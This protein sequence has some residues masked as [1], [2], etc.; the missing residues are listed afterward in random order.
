MSLVK[1]DCDKIPSEYRDAYPFTRQGV[2]VFLGEIANMKGHC[3]VAD[4]ITGQIY[5][6]YHSE[7]F[8]EISE[9]KLRIGQNAIEDGRPVELLPRPSAEYRI[10][11]RKVE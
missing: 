9:D 3:V 6:G 2:Y 8:V 5:S 4:H 10:E 7:H 1:F 11:G